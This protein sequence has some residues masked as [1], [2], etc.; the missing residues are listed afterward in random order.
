MLYLLLFY[1]VS[2]NLSSL[3]AQCL[4]PLIIDKPNPIILFVERKKS[5]INL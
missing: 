1:R 3:Y 2:R 5:Q 4:N